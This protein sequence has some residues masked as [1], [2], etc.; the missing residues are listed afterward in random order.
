M[1][2]TYCKYFL[3]IIILSAC[4]QTKI[5]GQGDVVPSVSFLNFIS[6]TIVVGRGSLSVL[7]SNSSL[8]TIDVDRVVKHGKVEVPN[9]INIQIPT[10]DT[11]CPAVRDV[12]PANELFFLKETHDGELTLSVSP[13]SQRCNPLADGYDVPDGAIPARWAYSDQ[14]LASDR[15]AYELAATI[16]AHNGVGPYAFVLNANILS[17]VSETGATYI[18]NTMARSH[19]SSLRMLG[20]IGLVR[21]GDPDTLQA[22]A[23]APQAYLNV[24]LPSQIYVGQSLL[25][26][27]PEQRTATFE[28]QV[29]LAV[30]A[31]T[32]PNTETIT[33]LSNLLS[34]STYTDLRLAAAKALRN[35]H[36][37][38]ATY[39]LGPYLWDKS[40]DVR[41]EAL[42]GVAC[43]AN[44]VPSIDNEKHPIPLDLNQPGSFK[45]SAT[46]M[47]FAVG[48]Q[49]IRPRE[50]FYLEFWRQWWTSNGPKV[51]SAE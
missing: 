7:D 33:Q 28:G 39:V 18:Y 21:L 10:V 16:E 48:T 20:T 37:P 19:I 47:H 27:P 26:T 30:A 50:S 42:A 43:F 6:D 41:D 51:E 31:I 46:V 13:N 1:I 29:I 11:S 25:S 40:E 36:T 8:L 2:S 23:S 12:T 4:P 5:F 44:A 15:L 17:G 32:N 3:L 24:A 35:M 9:T 22:L 34:Q 49:T 14:L 38:K 45:S